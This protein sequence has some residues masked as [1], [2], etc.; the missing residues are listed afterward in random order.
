MNEKKYSYL[1]IA[2]TNSSLPLILFVYES[3]RKMG[4][5]SSVQR[6][7]KEVR[8]VD[9][10]AVLKYIKEIGTHNSKHLEKIGK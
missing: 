3:L 7:H 6:N 1:K 8:I 9:R 2:F 4:I 10:E 5:R